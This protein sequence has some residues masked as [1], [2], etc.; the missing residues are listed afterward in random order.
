M[1]HSSSPLQTLIDAETRLI[2]PWLEHIFGYYGLSLGYFSQQL[3]LKSRSRIRYCFAIHNQ[4]QV[5]L[6]L[7]QNQCRA[8]TTQLPIASDSIDLV[9][10][11]HHLEFSDNPHQVLREIERILIP[12][13]RLIISGLNPWSLFSRQW[14]KFFIQE[15]ENN[16]EMQFISQTRTQDWLKL[17]GFDIEQQTRLICVPPLKNTLIRQYLAP[18]D[19]MIL[20]VFPAL[21]SIYLLQAVKMVATLT[22]IKPLWQ[23][24]PAFVSPPI[25]PSPVNR[26]ERK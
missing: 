13:G 9:I 4:K 3:R 1:I 22:P 21:S 14:L 8:K 17:L 2:T 26:N 7:G 15:F 16:Q 18:I 5:I 20:R 24:P 19:Q 6:E 23:K 10:A 25:Q 11:L 12:E